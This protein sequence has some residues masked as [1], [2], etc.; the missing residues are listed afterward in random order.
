MQYS[1]F[2][3]GAMALLLAACSSSEKDAEPDAAVGASKTLAMLTQD[4]RSAM[5]SW[6][7]EQ[8][9]ADG[10]WACQV[11]Q[12]TTPAQALAG[13]IAGPWWVACSVDDLRACVASAPSPFCRAAG[14]NTPECMK[15]NA[16]MKTQ[17]PPANCTSCHG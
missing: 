7:I 8:G 6:L 9:T 17:A 5:C 3:L 14:V 4:E 13:C 1:W 11:A 2:R 10:G 16:C 12:A 15:Y